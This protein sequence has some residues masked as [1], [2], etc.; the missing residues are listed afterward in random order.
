MTTALQIITS[1]MRKIGALTKNETPSADEASDGLEMLNDLLGSWST[2]SRLINVRTLESF[3]LT[4]AIEYSIGEGQDFDTTTPNFIE[5]AYVRQSTIDYPL[6][7]ITDQEY[8][9]IAFKDI[10]STPQYLNFDNGFPVGKI[11]LYPKSNA[12]HTLFLLSEKQTINFSSLS[13]DVAL[14]AGWSRALKYNLGIEIAPEYGQP[15]TQEIFEI[16]RRSKASIMRNAMRNKSIDAAPIGKKT[17]NI[18]V[19]YR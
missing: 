3:P 6:T 13:A 16:A 11:K 15:V 8:A 4:G 1:S 7:I 9:D 14:P 12:G 19:G 17:N 10:A 2:D 5:S 18:N